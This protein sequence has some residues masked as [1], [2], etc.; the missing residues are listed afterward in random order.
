MRLIPIHPENLRLAWKDVEK[1]LVKALKYN[2]EKYQLDDVKNLIQA[3][4]LVLWVVY[5]D[6]SG[7]AIG[8]LL[9]ETIQY[10]RTQALSIF[11]LG[12]ESFAQMNEC[13]EELQEYARGIG[14]QSI[15]LQGRPG[16]EKVLQPLKFEKTHTVMRH[17]L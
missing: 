9:T 6:E 4:S 8:C 2:D 17:L 12:G 14:C 11:L 3:E 15:E 13:F 10:P 1:H 7:K 5:N 16:W